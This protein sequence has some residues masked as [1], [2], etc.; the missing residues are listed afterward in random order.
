ML[1]EIPLEELAAVLDEIAADVL[2]KAGITEPPVDAAQ[3]AKRSGLTVAWDDRQSGRARVVKLPGAAGAAAPLI[4]LKH[5]ARSERQHW[6]IAHEI[7]ETLA[8]GA[9][10]QLGVD[11][12]EAPRQAREHVANGIASRLLL[13]RELFRADAEAC[14]WDLMELKSRYTTAS[15]ELIA[16]RMLDFTPP[17]IVSVFDQNRRTWRKSNLTDRLPKPSPAEIECQRM[18]HES[19][20]YLCSDGPSMVRAWPIHEPNWQREIVR[21]DVDEFQ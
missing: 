18:S 6:S 4:L 19:G 15:H 20:R 16:R 9:F 13:P 17:I 10:K 14:G 8:A 1:P 3:I 5:D 11:P 12:Q 2:A 7:G 21:V